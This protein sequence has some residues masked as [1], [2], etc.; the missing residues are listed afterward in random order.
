MMR[1]AALGYGVGWAERTQG[2]IARDRGA[3]A[4]AEAGLRAALETS[5]GIRARYEVARTRLDLAELADVQGLRGPAV[6]HLQ[7]ARALFVALRVPRCVERVDRF[8]E[9]LGAAP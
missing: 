3:L 2:R 9:K 6:A 4:E 1:E 7:A 8:A 5:E